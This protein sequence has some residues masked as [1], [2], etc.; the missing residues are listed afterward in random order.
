MIIVLLNNNNTPPL[1]GGPQSIRIA[2]PTNQPTV[3]ELG[4]SRVLEVIF[5]S[6]KD[7]RNS[8]DY[9][10]VS[11]RDITWSLSK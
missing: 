4:N 3:I 9:T 2:L 1:V 11:L 5:F 10:L 6:G 8:D 7:N